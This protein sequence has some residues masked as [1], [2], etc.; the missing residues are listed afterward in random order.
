MR[1]N[2]F[3][4]ISSF[5]MAAIL[6]VS[7]TGCSKNTV[8][9]TENIELIDPVGVAT[10]YSV[11]FTMTLFDSSIHSGMVYPVVTEYS[12]NTTQ[13]FKQYGVLP[14][15]AVSKNT[16]IIYANTEN[17]DNQLKSMKESLDNMAEQYTDYMKEASEKLEEDIEEEAKYK[18][19]MDNLNSMPFDASTKTYRGND[20][21]YTQMEYNNFDSK[22]R[23]TILTTLR[24]KE[25]I[26]ER[27]EL[28]ELDYAYNLAQYKEL[29]ATKD[30]ALLKSKI[31]G[32]LVWTNM[33]DN[34]AR[35]EA[36]TPVCAIGDLSKKVILCDFVNKATI[37]KAT[38]VYALINGKRYEVSY[39]PV[40]SEEYDRIKEEYGTVLSKFFIVDPDNSVK[41]GDFAVVVV[42]NSRHENCLVV[43]RD[44]ISK[45]NNGEFVYKYV[46]E[47]S[48][49]TP[50]KTG[51]KDGSFVEI[52]SGLS[53]G[54]YVLSSH[55]SKTGAK[56]I[57]L[58]KGYIGNEFKG[59]GYLFYPQTEWVTNPVEYGKTYIDELCVSMNQRVEK[60][61]VIARIH[62]VKDDIDI[63]RRE[64]T[65]LRAQEKLNELRA[66]DEGKKEE[67]KVN[68]KA[69]EAQTESIL[70]M[71]EVILNMKSDAKITEIKAPFSGIVT[72]IGGRYTEGDFI[73]NGSN[74]VQLAEE[75][76]SYI[77]VEDPNNQLTYGNEAAITYTNKNGEEKTVIGTVV[78]VNENCLTKSLQSGAAIISI[79][80]EALADMAGSAM[81]YGGYWFQT[82]FEVKAKIRCMDNVLLIPKSAVISADA[83]TYVTVKNPDGSLSTVPFVAGG[84]DMYNYWV[85]EGLTEGME[86]CLE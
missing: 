58:E 26:K 4:K 32:T 77:A 46:G 76:S 69:I 55:K 42:V 43:P 12:F 36:E 40:D 31:N 84:Y 85:V 7:F 70:S 17:L 29:K 68:T 13:N 71:Y 62:V 15:S 83:N 60:G 41:F 49:Y 6:T 65:M 47:E 37:T 10:E 25:A 52:L 44:A 33:F 8:S 28:Y 16:T 59:E 63:K 23:Q 53:D 79:P 1:K 66:Q 2:A 38:D 5:I 22:Y 19:I 57:V 11:A 48:I 75:N 64:R 86:I 81:S 78:T 67:D 30:N 21:S 14:G 73:Y 24:Q 39:Q 54:D 35:M 34:N 18:Q 82:R 80:R 9:S 72:G 20:R 45:D 56:T 61:D 50:V 51:A 3:L 27:T 74:I